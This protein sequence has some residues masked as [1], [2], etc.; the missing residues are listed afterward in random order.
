M[1]VIEIAIQG[2]TMTAAGA[3]VT[4]PDGNFLGLTQDRV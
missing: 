4:D 3:T 1:T 2:V